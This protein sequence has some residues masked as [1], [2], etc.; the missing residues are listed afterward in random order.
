MGVS[1]RYPGNPPGSAKRRDRDGNRVFSSRQARLLDE[2]G[3]AA[4][5]DIFMEDV[6][7]L[8]EIEAQRIVSRGVCAKSDTQHAYDRSVYSFENFCLRVLPDGHDEKKRLHRI[9]QALLDKE[10]SFQLT[11]TISPNAWMQYVAAM[12]A[13]V[14]ETFKFC[15]GTEFRGRDVGWKVVEGTWSALK[16][17]DEK[18]T[19]NPTRLRLEGIK[20][21]MEEMRKRY[22]PESASTFDV[23][24][25]LP[26]VHDAIFA[27]EFEGRPNP[28]RLLAHAP[29][30]FPSAKISAVEAVME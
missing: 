24:E 2:I 17:V 26:R 13:P 8:L 12:T 14:T 9:E 11:E 27:A 28:I 21:A 6:A 30:N 5:P 20:A 15:D 22:V 7:T 4:N 19:G 1:R 16:W 10:K 3:G 18:I 23:A 29:R 25:V